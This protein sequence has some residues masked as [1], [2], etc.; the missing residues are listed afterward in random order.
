[1]TSKPRKEV[2]NIAFPHKWE[3][4]AERRKE[5]G[6]TQKQLA[7]K[8]EVSFE[9]LRKIEVGKNNSAISTIAQIAYALDLKIDDLVERRG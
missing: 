6:L 1:M 5:F 3:R 8:A 7:E 2:V 4:I 9:T